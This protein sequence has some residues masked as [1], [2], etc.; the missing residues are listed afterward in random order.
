MDM[1][2]NL[3]D[4]KPPKQLTDARHAFNAYLTERP[5]AGHYLSVS[6][7]EAP[8]R[9]T[10]G[11]KVTALAQLAVIRDNFMWDDHRSRWTKKNGGTIVTE[12]KIYDVILSFQRVYRNVR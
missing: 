7:R 2:S 12:G 8:L 4:R 9:R 11:D 6:S 3:E 5:V 1:H 10:D